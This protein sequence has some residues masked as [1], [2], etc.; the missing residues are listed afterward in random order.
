LGDKDWG[1]TKVLPI[2]AV[3]VDVGIAAAAHSGK[4]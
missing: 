1:S 2:I 4:S 3:I